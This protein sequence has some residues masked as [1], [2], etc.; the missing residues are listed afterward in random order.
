MS[1]H[2]ALLLPASQEESEHGDS[3]SESR[4]KHSSLARISVPSFLQ[5]RAKA[6]HIPLRSPVRRKPLPESASPRAVSYTRH[7]ASPRAYRDVQPAVAQVDD[8]LLPQKTADLATVD[9]PRPTAEIVGRD[10]EQSVQCAGG[11]TFQEPV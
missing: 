1:A 7:L 9:A 10:L 6:S 3:R 5:F 8:S 11:S 2:H 4:R